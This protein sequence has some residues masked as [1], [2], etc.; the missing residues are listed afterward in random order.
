M[1]FCLVNNL[2]APYSRGGTEKIVKQISS[3]LKNYGQVLIITTQPD[4]VL[5]RQTEDD[6]EI[7]RFR[8]KNLYYLLDDYKKNLVLKT[9]WHF[10]DMFCHKTCDIVEGI[11]S[12]QRPDFVFTHNLKG[13]GLASFKV[14][15]KL[16]LS[17]IHT[18]HD[19]Q[20][21]DPHGSMHRLGQNLPLNSP[22]Y[23]FY[24]YL[25]RKAVGR[26]DLV[27]SPS[28]FVLDKHLEYGFFNEAERVVLPNPVEAFE[29]LKTN[30]F[31]KK[32]TL[33]YLGQI[34][35]HKGVDFLIKAFKDF[36]KGDSQLL[37]AGVG[38]QLDR[39]RELAYDD[40]RIKVL[41]KV[42][43]EELPEL[44]S[45]SDLLVLP[46]IWWENSPT[47]IYEAYASKVPVLVSSNGGSKELVK[48]GQ[49]GWI[50]QSANKK[51]LLVKLNLALNFRSKL[52]EMGLNGYRLA[53]EYSL[54]NYIKK[55]LEL[56]QA[57]KR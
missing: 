47:V 42:S 16:G 34:E 32:F 7:Y 14:I 51:S 40:E 12:K 9:A 2:F 5:T 18:L 15:R 11:L 43:Q 35:E 29:P 4:K 23:R 48:D 38:S 57:L 10:L 53:K 54:D 50:F 27:I 39:I 17:H 30:F 44:F 25:T 37:I 55:L 13:L 24:R 19:Y 26:P 56:C 22:F 1:K 41:G 49:T 28:K 52:P 6:V 31:S 45:Q 8:P 33:L 20:L 21:L 3:G 36:K 46:S